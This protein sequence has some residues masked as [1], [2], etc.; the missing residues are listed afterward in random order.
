MRMERKQQTDLS[1][2]LLCS[3]GVEYGLN[4]F[5]LWEVALL[6]GLALP[7]EVCHYEVE[8]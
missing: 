3:Q 2:A 6:G 5:G 1:S 8:L 4:T 7:E